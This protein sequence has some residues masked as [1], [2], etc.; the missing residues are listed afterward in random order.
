MVGFRA[1]TAQEDAAAR[2]I[3]V[4]LQDIRVWLNAHEGVV[5]YVQVLHN[6]I[7]RVVFSVAVVIAGNRRDGVAAVVLEALNE[8]IDQ[9]A[10]FMDGVPEDDQT[11][12]LFFHLIDLM[13]TVNEL[14]R[15]L[16]G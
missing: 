13:G 7:D 2:A 14:K 3:E 6:I 15:L 10:A 8:G 9:L 4:V 1:F 5:E 16:S 11:G 12:D